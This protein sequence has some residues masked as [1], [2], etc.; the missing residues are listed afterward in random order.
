M[1]NIQFQVGQRV[2]IL[3]TIVNTFGRSSSAMRF[4]TKEAKENHGKFATLL[5]VHYVYNPSLYPDCE[6][7]LEGT[8]K[9]FIIEM[10]NL[11]LVEA[12]PPVSK[13]VVRQAGARKKMTP[14]CTLILNHLKAG[15]TITQRSALMDFGIMALPRRIADLKQYFS[16]PVISVME[17]NK[18]TGQRYARYFMSKAA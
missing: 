16:V 15:N 12:K 14:Q 4:F 10:C 9:K 6:V 18:L 17:H 5:S 1:N 2:Q 13:P 7:R 8:G 11:Q 3:D